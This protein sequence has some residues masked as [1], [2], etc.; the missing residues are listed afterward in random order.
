MS[1][2]LATVSFSVDRSMKEDLDRLSSEEGRSKSDLFR[3]M[4]NYYR[5]KIALRRV[6]EHGAL[7]AARLGLGSDDEVYEYLNKNK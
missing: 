2:S 1:H 5:F 6:Q 4:Y 3:E 7:I